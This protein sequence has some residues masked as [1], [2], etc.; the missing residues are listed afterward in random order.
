MSTYTTTQTTT[1]TTQNTSYIWTPP[2]SV[3]I[4][5][6][7]VNNLKQV[8]SL[9]ISG[10]TG[11]QLNRHNLHYNR[12]NDNGGTILQAEIEIAKQ[13]QSPNGYIVWDTTAARINNLY[14]L[15]PRGGTNPSCMYNKKQT[16]NM[17]KESQVLYLLTDGEIDTN[18]VQ[19]HAQKVQQY[20]GHLD[21]SVGILVVSN[22]SV[23]PADVNISVLASAMVGNSL[24]AIWNK[25]KNGLNI[26]WA[27]GEPANRLSYEQITPQTTWDDLPVISI[28]N[29]THMKLSISS[30]KPPVGYTMMMVREENVWISI[31]RLFKSSIEFEQLNSLPL[32]D[33]LRIC[34]DR[35]LLNNLR[36]WLKFNEKRL[37]ESYNTIDIS[38]V[39]ETD[40]ANKLLVQM[41]H[42]IENNDNELASTLREI[43]IKLRNIAWAKC[44]EL[45][46]NAAELVRPLKR[47]FSSIYDLIHQLQKSS[48]SVSSLNINLKSNRAMRADHVDFGEETMNTLDYTDAVCDQCPICFEDTEPICVLLRT[49]QDPSTNTNDYALNW[50]LA[51][52]L[53]NV[54]V[55][56]PQI[57]C[58]KC[59]DYF[60]NTRRDT[61][62]VPINHVLP[63]VS[64]RFPENRK[65]V[66]NIIAS[67]LT[68]GKLV[69]GLDIFLFGMM[70]QVRHFEWGQSTTWTTISKFV[71]QELLTHCYG[72]DTFT[73]DGT[74]M[75]LR[76]AMP[77][78]LKTEYIF[79]QPIN[80]IQTILSNVNEF[81]LLNVTAPKTVY[82]KVLRIAIVRNIIMLFLK[83]KLDKSTSPLIT[84]IND[85]LFEVVNTVP[86][87]HTTRLTSFSNSQFIKELFGEW[88]LNFYETLNKTC[89]QL[90]LNFSLIMS[91][92]IVT[93]V[94]WIILNR[95]EHAPHQRLEDM[96]KTLIKQSPLFGLVMSNDLINQKTII[97][98]I[99]TTMFPHVYADNNIH[100]VPLFVTVY[101]PSSIDCS[102]GETFIGLHSGK[103][104][105]E[106]VTENVRVTRA[107]HFSIIYGSEVPNNRSSHTD[108]HK[109][110]HNVIR[111][112][113][114]FSK[115]NNA[116]HEVY[117]TIFKKLIKPYGVRGNIF[118]R[119]LMDHVKIATNSYFVIKNKMNYNEIKDF[120]GLQEKL[121]MEL[122]DRKMIDNNKLV[123]IK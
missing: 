70:D 87:A 64:M 28:E 114:K 14:Q 86:I 7:S 17:I 93:T 77:S 13:I 89:D 42:A 105:I 51:V 95:L 36:T 67:S 65:Y 54:Q 102:C 39:D 99:E 40:Q 69:K 50:P 5:S 84:L 94:L 1:Q 60:M 20:A 66:R 75:T 79:R 88:Y 44:A 118:K 76:L 59:S 103:Y 8:V 109:T 26:L 43:F 47:F 90:G 96:I 73:E 112:S 24:I 15:G 62:R 108:L 117:N 18:A 123:N 115:L 63:C 25:N 29:I 122:T 97:N 46:Q 31:D 98:L 74:R 107:K 58:I 104:T 106:E 80:S 92:T 119:E 116:T 9:D 3:K 83:R 48:Y 22:R 19:S 16:L 27:N 78:V 35:G 49:H 53:L 34:R 21:L 121:F 56:S 38:T 68:A 82:C 11:N 85:D 32:D 30:A 37:L 100:P 113:V 91:D 10:S 72:T 101:G 33:I 120:V 55:L 45:Q 6:V 41:N 23:M 71:R 61:V 81:N 12:S 2:S 110:V 52:G 4:Q 111:N 57:V